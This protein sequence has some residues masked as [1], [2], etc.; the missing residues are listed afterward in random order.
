MLTQMPCSCFNPGLAL[1]DITSI[2]NPHLVAKNNKLLFPVHR[3]DLVCLYPEISFVL[4]FL[5]PVAGLQF[6]SLPERQ[7]NPGR[8]NF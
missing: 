7:K 5:K 6:A 4:Q 8:M 2:P 3:K 1:L